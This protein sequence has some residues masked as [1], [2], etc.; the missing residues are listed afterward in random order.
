MWWLTTYEI[1]CSCEISQFGVS[2]KRISCHLDRRSGRWSFLWSYGT[3]KCLSRRLVH[4][5]L[6]QLQWSIAGLRSYK[7]CIMSC[8]S[9]WNVHVVLKRKMETFCNTSNVRMWRSYGSC[10]QHYWILSVSWR[11]LEVLKK[12]CPHFRQVASEEHCRPWLYPFRSRTSTT[13]WKL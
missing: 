2:E 12:H 8:R 13:S 11:T 7:Q 5:L 3:H 9:T 1:Q 10:L 4:R 6:V